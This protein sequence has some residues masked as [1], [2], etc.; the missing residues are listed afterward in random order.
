MGR[1]ASHCRSGV[2]ASFCLGTGPL[3]ASSVLDVMRQGLGEKLPS[4]VSPDDYANL[5]SS[6]HLYADP[7]ALLERVAHLPGHTRTKVRSEVVEL[8]PQQTPQSIDDCGF[9]RSDGPHNV[10]RRPSS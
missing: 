9:D 8:D 3:E 1:G 6:P 7:I 10:K 2:F 4:G 5:L